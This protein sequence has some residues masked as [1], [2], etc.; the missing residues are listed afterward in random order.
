MRYLILQL[1]SIKNRPIKFAK[2]SYIGFMKDTKTSNIE[3]LEANVI[4]D[5]SNICPFWKFCVT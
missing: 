2:T 4:A 5:R 3:C 1:I